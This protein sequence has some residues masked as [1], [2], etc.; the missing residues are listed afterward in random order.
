MFY[1]VY[2]SFDI[3]KR[4]EKQKDTTKRKAK[5]SDKKTVEHKK[6]N[7]PIFAANYKYIFT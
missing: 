3:I 7:I 5:K 2:C 4:I 6:N 1:F